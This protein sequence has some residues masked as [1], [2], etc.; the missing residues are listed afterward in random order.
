MREALGNVGCTCREADHGCTI[1][2]PDDLLHSHDALHQAAGWV[3]RRSCRR[4]ELPGRGPQI[5]HNYAVDIILD[6][7]KTCPGEEGATEVMGADG[8]AHEQAGQAFLCHC[9]PRGNNNTSGLLRCMV[10]KCF[11]HESTIQENMEIVGMH[12]SGMM[13]CSCQFGP[14]RDGS[15]PLQHDSDCTMVRR[16]MESYHT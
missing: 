13:L 1:A 10:V 2:A 15:L 8:C 16:N 3:S 4:C 5:L 12:C 9:Q 14:P 7:Q 11:V 6:I